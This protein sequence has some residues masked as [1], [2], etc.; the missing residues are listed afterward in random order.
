MNHFGN[1]PRKQT[2]WPL[3]WYLL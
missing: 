3:F 1:T 2:D